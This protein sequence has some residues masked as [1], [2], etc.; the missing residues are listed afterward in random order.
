MA[1]VTETIMGNDTMTEANEQETM[2]DLVEP[3]QT[4]VVGG[5]NT[6]VFCDEV[7]NA[8]DADD[9]ANDDADGDSN[10]DTDDDDD[11]AVDD[12]AV[13]DDDEGDEEKEGND[14][15]S[16]DASDHGA[17]SV[18]KNVGKG[19]GGDTFVSI[20]IGKKACK[21]AVKRPRRKISAAQ[22]QKRFNAHVKKLSCADIKE[23]IQYAPFQRMIVN[24]LSDGVERVSTTAIHAL[25]DAAVNYAHEIYNDSYTIT[26]VSNKK[27]TLMLRHVAGA[28]YAKGTVTRHPPV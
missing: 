9:D 11:D 12:D 23:I 13:D 15:G 27:Q 1:S 22:R 26:K 18:S 17:K 2:E 20:G 19:K 7:L 16:D 5:S 24:A 10:D 3:E 21:V 28:M 6:K 4:Q 25:M 8:D 14:E